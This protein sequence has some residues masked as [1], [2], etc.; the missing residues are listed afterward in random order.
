SLHGTCN[1]LLSIG[2]AFDS[3]HSVSQYCFLYI[4]LS[5][6]N[7]M[8]HSVC[9]KILSPSIVGLNTGLLMTLFVGVDRLFSVLIPT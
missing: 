5:G 4:A 1:Y 7:F 9:V 2:G 3:L 8:S 6:R